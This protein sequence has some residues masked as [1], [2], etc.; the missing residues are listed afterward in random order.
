MM[1]RLQIRNIRV[2]LLAL[3]II[4]CL[5]VYFPYSN[6]VAK[7]FGNGGYIHVEDITEQTYG[8]YTK[9]DDMYEEFVRKRERE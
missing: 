5:Q 8:Q 1:S 7:Y 9:A 6:F 2:I 4:S 3:I